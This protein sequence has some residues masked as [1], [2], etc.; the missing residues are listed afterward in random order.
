LG[1]RERAE[2]YYN[3]EYKTLIIRPANIMAR[4]RMSMSLPPADASIT[5]RLA[6]R[7]EWWIC[8]YIPRVQGPFRLGVHLSWIGYLGGWRDEPIST[9]RT[10][11]G[12]CSPAS[13]SSGSGFLPTSR[14]ASA[15][16]CSTRFPPVCISRISSHRRN[17]A[18]Q[19][20]A[21]VVMRVSGFNI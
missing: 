13:R 21:V 6:S 11:Q 19:T 9:R 17:R 7:A 18:L 20:D 1:E 2:R 3:N 15:L 8:L 4:E 10:T 12:F 5:R 16:C 14:S